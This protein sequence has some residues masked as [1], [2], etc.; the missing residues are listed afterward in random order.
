MA[1]TPEG[2]WFHFDFTPGHIQCRWLTAPLEDLT[3]KITIIGT[4]LNE[5]ALEQ[6][7]QK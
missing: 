6:L 2:K 5:V 4:V 3:S 7:F 1:Q